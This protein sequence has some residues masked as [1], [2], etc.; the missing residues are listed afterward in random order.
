MG[1]ARLF[2]PRYAHAARTQISCTL[3]YPTIAC[4]AFFK[5]SRMECANATKLHRKFGEPGAPL[6]FC[7]EKTV[8]YVVVAFDMLSGGRT[9]AAAPHCGFGLGPISNS[10]VPPAVISSCLIHERFSALLFNFADCT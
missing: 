7:G 10:N 8:S 3:P 9:A 4:A 5:E 1:V 6:R 2:R